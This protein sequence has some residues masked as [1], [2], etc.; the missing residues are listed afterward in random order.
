MSQTFAGGALD[1]AGMLRRDPAWLVQALLA[2]HAR[3]ALLH[4]LAPLCREDGLGGLVA[5]WLSQGERAG[6]IGAG[7]PV[8]LGLD[9]AGA[10]HFALALAPEA[11]APLELLEDAHFEE[12]RAA[13]AR[14]AGPDAAALGC[15]K[16]L[17]DWHARHGFC[18][19]CGA[20]TQQREGGWKRLCLRCAA[21]HFPRTDPVVIMLPTAGER[22]VVGRQR[23]FPPGVYSALAG[24]VELGESLEEAVARETLEEIGLPLRGLRYWGSQ[25]WPFPSSLMLGFHAEVEEG[26][27]RLDL[28]ELEDAR[29]LTRAEAQA[30]LAGEGAV[31]FPPPLAIA[32]WLLRTWAHG[33]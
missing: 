1:R 12:L 29:W 24:F 16:A 10:P 14:L 27:L 30:G 32:H 19:R 15:A 3:F 5:R 4:G 23:R 20:P 11:D 13:A 9:G 17:L 2:P 25:P 8:L 31:R 26:P 21:E 18:A 6:L 22:C 7:E 33:P 28:E